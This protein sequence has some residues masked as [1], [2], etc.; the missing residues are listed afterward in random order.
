MPK[1]KA[2]K[3]KANTKA[4]KKASKAGKRSKS[5]AMTESE[6]VESL[7][8]KL[9]R[10]KA[11]V[12]RELALQSQVTAQALKSRG[13]VRTPLGTMKVKNVPARKGGQLVRNPF[14]GEMVKAKPKPASKRV[15]L[16]PGKKFKDL[17]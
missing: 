9:N 2:A 12:K 1:K 4:G 8:E 15:R 7:A 6:Y 17:V 14:T 5:R 16:S 10:P 3:K 13:T 11:E